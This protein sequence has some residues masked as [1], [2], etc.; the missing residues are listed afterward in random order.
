MRVS[1]SD[2]RAVQF[3]VALRGYAEDE[4]DALLALVIETL[5]EYEQRDA[6]ARE[7]LKR[8]RSA[9]DGCREALVTEN[10]DT[11]SALHR[12]TEARVRDMLEEAGRMTERII[13]E[14]LE[15][16]GKILRHVGTA[17]AI[18]SGGDAGEPQADS[19]PDLS[20]PGPEG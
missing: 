5:L 19:L 2:V 4:V 17:T 7:E 10:L 16:G 6:E 3:A 18:P 13:G 20:D 9:L 11:L 8:L 14:A 12:E 15:A 1:S